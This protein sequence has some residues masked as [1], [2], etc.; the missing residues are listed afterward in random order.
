MYQAPP[1][2]FDLAPERR[3]AGQ[4]R[5]GVGEEIGVGGERGQ[6]GERPADV[7]GDDPEQRFRR[8][9]E[10]ADVEVAVEEQRRDA[11]AV[12][13]V[14]QIVGRAALPFE[15]LLKLAVERGQLL[16]ERLQLLLR[17]YQLLVGG[18]ELLVDRHRFFVDRRL[19]L[20]GDLE[21]ADGALQFLAG[22]VELALELGDPRDV[23]AGR[24]AGP[25]GAR[26]LGFVDEADQQQL[27]ALALHRLDLDADRDDAAAVA[28]RRAGDD[29]AR[30]LL[31][32]LL[33]RRP[34]LVAQPVA[35]HGQQ[36]AA[37]LARR[38]PADSGRSVPSNRGTRPCG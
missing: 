33:D 25:A 26:A 4:H 23:S 18:L 1:S 7:G 10:E 9:R 30:V 5:A 22:G 14:L 12:E 13:N 19:L 31:A 29:G 34:E 8:R 11:G 32:G 17:G 16:V 36:I 6:I 20:V 3:E 15:R 21:V 24:P 28:R 2:R 37:G 35:R 27:L 38:R